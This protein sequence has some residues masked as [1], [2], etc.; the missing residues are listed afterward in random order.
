MDGIC[1]ILASLHCEHPQYRRVLDELKSQANAA[2]FF[3]I[4]VGSSSYLDFNGLLDELIHQYGDHELKKDADSY[5]KDLL[6]FLGHTTVKQAANPQQPWWP[7]R[8]DNIPPKFTKVKTQVLKDPDTFRLIDLISCRMRFTSEIGLHH[9]IF[10]I[11]GVEELNSFGVSWLVPSI[12][13]PVLEDAVK[14]SN[15]VSIFQT[16]E[17]TSLSIMTERI[18]YTEEVSLLA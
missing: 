3:Q 2:D 1:H 16:Y 15:V 12:L 18:L 6:T 11:I 17:I 14:S 9:L 4:L 8:Y 7:A 5:R 10:I 13:V